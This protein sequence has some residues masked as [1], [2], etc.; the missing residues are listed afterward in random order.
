MRLLHTTL[1][2]VQWPSEYILIDRIKHN[3][4]SGCTATALSPIPYRQFNGFPMKKFTTLFLL[5]FS[6]SAGIGQTKE[7]PSF[8]FFKVDKKL[9]SKI[10][11][12]KAGSDF[13]GMAIDDCF[14]FFSDSLDSDDITP[15][16]E[17]RIFFDTLTTYEDGVCDCMIRN[18]T[19]IL[20]GGIAY[21]GG[22]GFDV[23]ITKETFNG[24]IWISGEGFKTDSTADF[25][26]EIL[27]KS[28]YQTL[29]IQ[30]RKTIASGKTLVGEIFME[31]E[32][33]LSKDD[34]RPNKFYMKIL[35]SCKLDGYIVF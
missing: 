8:N 18:D 24:N 30:D 32:K 26:G 27:L 22:I 34:Q 31:S 12:A 11:K 21:E 3:D 13:K 33:F 16:T 14:W 15:V 2:F 29:K 23:R 4:S 35:F 7:A 1:G 5:L 19:A 10:K 20:Q 9:A 17:F 25:Q 6:G 28:I